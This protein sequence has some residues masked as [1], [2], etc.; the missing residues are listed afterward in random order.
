MSNLDGDTACLVS[1]LVLDVLRHGV[2]LGQL[3]GVLRPT[4]GHA[5]Q[6]ADVLEHLRKGHLCIDDLT[7]KGW[8]F[9]SH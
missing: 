3:H 5:P 4:L 7:R 1:N 9:I 8:G 2:K 6:L